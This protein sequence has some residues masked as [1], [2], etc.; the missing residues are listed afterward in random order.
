MHETLAFHILLYNLWSTHL[1]PLKVPT[2]RI[3][4]QNFFSDLLAAI[5]TVQ[6]KLFICQNNF[7]VL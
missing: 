7:T 4:K 5:L 1:R 3:L 2:R 6:L